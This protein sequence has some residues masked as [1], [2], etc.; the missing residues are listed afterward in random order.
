TTYEDAP[1]ELVDFFRPR[2]GDDDARLAAAVASMQDSETRHGS[3][4]AGLAAAGIQP[5][6]VTD[7]IL[8]HL[9]WDHCGW[10]SAGG[11]TLLPNAT[12]HAERHALDPFLGETPID[13]SAFQA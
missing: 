7:V 4:P 11:E 9:H 5:E 6:D 13:G 12:I 1:T 2:L 8:S 3:L 10:V